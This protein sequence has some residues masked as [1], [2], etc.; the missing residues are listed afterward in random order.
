MNN[1]LHNSMIKM[2]IFHQCIHSENDFS[3]KPISKDSTKKYYEIKVTLTNQQVVFI[4]YYQRNESEANF[5]YQKE[6]KEK[7]FF[8]PISISSNL[9]GTYSAIHCYFHASRYVIG[10][11]DDI[12]L[13]IAKQ[14]Q[15][16]INEKKYSYK[17][18]NYNIYKLDKWIK[19]NT[20]NNPLWYI[21]GYDELKDSIN[22]TIF[23]S[24]SFFFHKFMFLRINFLLNFNYRITCGYDKENKVLFEINGKMNKDDFDKDFN[25]AIKTIN[26]EIN[27]KKSYPFLESKFPEKEDLDINKN[28]IELMDALNEYSNF[29]L[30]NDSIKDIKN[31][32]N[33][34][35]NLEESIRLIYKSK[36]LLKEDKIDD[37][38]KHILNENIKKSEILYKEHL[39]KYNSFINLYIVQSKDNLL[40]KSE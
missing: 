11:W 15:K 26:K 9:L 8:S 12:D 5:I 22:H 1:L 25:K 35:I 19:T 20:K 10:R 27:S 13:K 3:V 39:K 37:L 34:K 31:L 32:I 6:N 18:F 29:K 17:D 21:N 24:R 2:L 33:Y 40:I 23:L 7:I 4:Y 16:Y 28:I 38:L 36:L 14:L 30:T